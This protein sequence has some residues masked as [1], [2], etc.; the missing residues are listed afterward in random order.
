MSDDKATSN[1]LLDDIRALG[2]DD[3]EAAWLDGVA[4]DEE[5]FGEEVADVR[6]L[7]DLLIVVLVLMINWA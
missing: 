1:D 4:S 7:R 6:S 2:G 5:I 3:D